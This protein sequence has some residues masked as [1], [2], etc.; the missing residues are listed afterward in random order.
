MTTAW[1]T[2]FAGIVYSIAT[3][4]YMQ[5]LEV[6][7]NEFKLYIVNEHIKKKIICNRDLGFTRTLVEGREV[8]D[9]HGLSL[10]FE[11]PKPRPAL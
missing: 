7:V 1:V 6:L 3:D 2:A 10:Y 9:S 11:P 8:M 4:C 5:I